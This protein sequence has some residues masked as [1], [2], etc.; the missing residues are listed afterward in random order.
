MGEYVGS[1]FSLSV[2]L[3]RAIA[4]FAIFEIVVSTPGILHFVKQMAGSEAPNVP[5]MLAI[6][7]TV[8]SQATG[9][10]LLLIYSKRFARFLTRGLAASDIAIDE[11]SYGV[12]QAAAFSLLGMYIL[13]HAFPALAKMAAIYFLPDVKN[14]NPGG[15]F[16]LEFLEPKQRVVASDIV[17]VLAE[18]GLGLWLL[19]GSRGIVRL[20]GRSRT[21][22][23]PYRPTVC[24]SGAYR[25]VR[26]PD[27]ASSRPVRSRRAMTREGLRQRNASKN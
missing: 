26:V 19:L 10:T 4:F 21:R 7:G 27:Q 13:V 12:L 20:I 22:S 3:L 16:S 25:A 9:A 15:L 24:T 11:T 1:F 17:A 6:G 8:L 23:S 5:D 14:P 2:V 18:L